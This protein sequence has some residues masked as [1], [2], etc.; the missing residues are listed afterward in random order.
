MKYNYDE[1][2]CKCPKCN[3]LGMPWMAYFT[4]EDRGAVFHIGLGCEVEVMP[5]KSVRIKK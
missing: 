1:D 3:G 2:P 5:D 4:C